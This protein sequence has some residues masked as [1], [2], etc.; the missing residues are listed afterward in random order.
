MS[1]LAYEHNGKPV[2]AVRFYEIACDPRR[3]VAVEACAGS[4]KTWMLVSRILRALLAGA[5][6]HEI[7]AI[8]F[9]KKA[10]GEMRQ[11]L[12]DWLSDFA[13]APAERLARELLARGIARPTDDEV[14][15]LRGLYARVLAAGRPVRILTFHAWFASL[16]RNAPLAVMERLALPANYQLLEDDSEAV[17]LVW[18]RFHV[19][20]VAQPEA[21]ADFEASVAAH[22][23][24]QT[25]KALAAALAKRVEFTFAETYGAI[26]ASVKPFG[27]QFPELAGLAE[28][29]DVLARAG[30]PHQLMADA[31]RAL[32]RAKAPTYSAKGTELEL[33]LAARDLD[34]ALAALLTQQGEARKFSDKLEGLPAIRSA[35]ELALRLAEAC[36]QHQ[37]WLHHHRM[38][39]LTRVLVD[40]FAALKREHGWIDMN[41]VEQAAQMMLSDSVL[42]GWVQERLDARIRHLLVDEFQDTNPLQ[43]QALHS[44]LSG[45]AGAGGDV[46]GIFIVGD[47]KQSIYRFRRAEPQVFLAAQ[48]FIQELGGDRL[49]CDH[50]RRNSQAVIGAVNAVMAQAQDE[51]DYEGFRAHSTDSTDPGRVDS[52]PQI[53]RAAVAGAAP[54]ARRRAAGVGGGGRRRGRAGA[55]ARQPHHAARPGGRKTRRTRMP[56]GRGLDRG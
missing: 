26:A 55:V 31:A 54:P 23:R 32:G 29:C 41:D 39:R 14:K 33:A 16:L 42:S 38:A 18:R 35:Q 5:Q 13:Q 30:A 20:L 7:L 27:E 3:G 25:R 8:T 49:S 48:E 17:D 47:P 1:A 52:L 45:Y 24:S 22:G 56:P 12:H 37:A 36:R 9:T 34:G 4:G 40:E 53:P 21:R 11:R 43:W 19:A 44:W 6:P 10:A 51:G 50:T 2:D 46:P 15:A 28:P